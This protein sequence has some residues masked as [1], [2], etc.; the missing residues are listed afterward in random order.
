M[1]G[2]VSVERDHL[3]DDPDYYRSGGIRLH[4]KSQT[5]AIDGVKEGILLEAGFDKVTPNDKLTISSWAY[6]KA[7]QGDIGVIDNR[8][9]DITCYHP[10]YT[11]VKKLQ[12]T[13]T[14]FRQEQNDGIARPNYMRQYYDVYC[15]LND[16]QV[17][18]FIGTE[19]YEAHKKERFP[20]QDY[21]ILL[22]ENCS[23]TI[24]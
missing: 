4:Y 1:D 15:L 3:F 6:E 12:T 20:K 16:A 19:A 24:F 23:C 11:F 10:C 7:R 21:A 8:A 14:K 5:T 13:A 18:D 17:L 22:S 9:V 2:I